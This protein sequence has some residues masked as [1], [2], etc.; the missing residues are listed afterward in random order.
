MT[1]WEEINQEVWLVLI[2][3]SNEKNAKEWIQTQLS[4]K[5][6]KEFSTSNWVIHFV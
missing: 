3:W 2:N 6:R 1:D 5:Q 4:V